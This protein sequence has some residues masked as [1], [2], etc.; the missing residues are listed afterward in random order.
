VETKFHADRLP[1]LR[2]RRSAS[3]V[4]KLLDAPW[5][6]H[7]MLDANRFSLSVRI[8]ARAGCPFS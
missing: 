3:S 4:A 6:S 8:R 5:Q 7:A 1:M 2:L